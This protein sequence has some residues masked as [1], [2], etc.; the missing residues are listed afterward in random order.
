MRRHLLTGAVFCT[1]VL[2]YAGEYL[3]S[4]KAAMAVGWALL[5]AMFYERLG[6]RAAAAAVILCAF[7]APA[8]AAPQQRYRYV[9]TPYGAAAIPIRAVYGANGFIRYEDGYG[10][11]RYT[12]PAPGIHDGPKLGAFA[13]GGGRTT[14]YNPE[15]DPTAR[16][17][18][19]PA[20]YGPR[21][22]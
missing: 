8:E 4:P 3:Q 1:V 15:N 22:R 19:R 20:Y 16:A 12:Q 14:G 17:Q 6:A 7:A 18:A 2:I 13:P 21:A 10:Y 11:R 5:F 9:P